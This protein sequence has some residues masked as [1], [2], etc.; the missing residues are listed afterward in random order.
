M[1][2]YVLVKIHTEV[3]KNLRV[4][5]DVIEANMNFAYIMLLL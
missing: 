3:V 2:A 1:K 4:V 5:H